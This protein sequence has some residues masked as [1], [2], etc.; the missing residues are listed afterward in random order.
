[1]IKPKGYNVFPT[2]VENVIADA[3]KEKVENVGVV[4][5]EHEVF[6]EGIIAFVEK[7]KGKDITVDEVNDVC[8]N[9]AAYKRPSHV[10]ILEYN[11][12]PLNRINKTDYVALKSLA[13][14][15]IEK[16]RAAAGWDRN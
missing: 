2:E 3:M 4:G 1:M 14:Q 12:M 9:M 13:K 11:D 6:S 10:V 5:H 7:K 16:L 8:K 15:E